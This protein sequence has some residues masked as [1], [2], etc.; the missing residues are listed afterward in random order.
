MVVPSSGPL[1]RSRS[2]RQRLLPADESWHSTLDYGQPFERSGLHVMDAPTTHPTETITG[3]GST[4]AQLIIAHV[5]GAPIHAHPMIPTLQVSGTRAGAN[6]DLALDGETDPR[7]V[8]AELE[9]LIAAV[10]ARTYA[11][12]L[13]EL[14]L[15]DFQLTRGRLG[16]SM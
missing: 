9:R 16:V 5:E 2:F 4:G 11:P 10:A 7:A 12:R 6:L 8:A 13:V 14:G 3:L 15:T 1:G